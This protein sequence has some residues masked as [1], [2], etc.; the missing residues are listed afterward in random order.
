MAERKT[1]WKRGGE[2]KVI[3]SYEESYGYMMGDYVGTKD[4]I[5]A[6][7]VAARWR[8]GISGRA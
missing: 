5:T 8:P 6:A 4:A 7:L 2:G 1:P 3:F